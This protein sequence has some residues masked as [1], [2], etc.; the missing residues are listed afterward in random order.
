M[1][2]PHYSGDCYEHHNCATICGSMRFYDKMLQVA[3]RLTIEGKIV[4]MPFVVKRSADGATAHPPEVAA[5]LDE[6]HK[7]KIDLSRSIYVV[8]DKTGYFG[9]STCGEID[10]AIKQNKR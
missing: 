5:A 7:R 2:Y 3:E 9:E 10:Y 1:G 4:L 6:L 8:S